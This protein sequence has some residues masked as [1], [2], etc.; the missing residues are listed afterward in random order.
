MIAQSIG[1]KVVRRQAGLLTDTSW[2]DS[3]CIL[4]VGKRFFVTYFWKS[5]DFPPPLFT[6]FV[7]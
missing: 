3:F 7:F 2:L 5:T 1:E 4:D 6:Y